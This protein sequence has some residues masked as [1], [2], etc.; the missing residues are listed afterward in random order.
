MQ[1]SQKTRQTAGQLERIPNTNSGP[2]IERLGVSES[3][4]DCRECM[5][6]NQQSCFDSCDWWFVVWLASSIAAWLAGW[7]Q[8][9]ILLRLSPT[10]GGVRA[11]VGL[12]GLVGSSGSQGRLSGQ[13]VGRADKRA[14]DSSSLGPARRVSVLAGCGCGLSGPRQGPA[15]IQ[16]A[17]SRARSVCVDLALSLSLSLSA[18]AFV[19]L[20]RRP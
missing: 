16:Q 13:V 18:R 12:V 2:D 19:R 9:A 3:E 14:F 10:L 8:I 4:R 1:A 11:L 20:E 17:P 5:L 6:R 15:R 7:P